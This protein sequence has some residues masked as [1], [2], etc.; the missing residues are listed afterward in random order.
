MHFI[1]FALLFV[2]LSI[3]ECQPWYVQKYV[4][5]STPEDV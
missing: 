1:G 2:D 5:V 3:L 4:Y